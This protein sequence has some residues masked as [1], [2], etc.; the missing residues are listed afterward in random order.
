MTK[1]FIKYHPYTFEPIYQ[2]VDDEDTFIPNME[3]KP[4]LEGKNPQEF[5]VAFHPQTKRISSVT[6][7]INN[8]KPKATIHEKGF[9]TPPVE[10]KKPKNYINHNIEPI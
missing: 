9:Y 6:P 4:E 7:V 5:D 2:Y 10:I 8:T 1:K 3:F